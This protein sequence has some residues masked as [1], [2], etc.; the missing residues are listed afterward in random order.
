MQAHFNRIFFVFD[1][2]VPGAVF[3]KLVDYMRPHIDVKKIGIAIMNHVKETNESISRF[4]C[5]LIPV[6]ILCKANKIEDFIEF[7]KPAILAQFPTGDDAERITWSVE[8][9]RRNN[10]KVQKKDFVDVLTKE[11]DTVQHPVQY[12]DAKVEILIEIFRDMLIFAIL[13][14]YKSQFRKYNI[15]QLCSGKDEE[16]DEQATGGKVIK[17]SDLLKKKK[18][19]NAEEQVDVKE[20]VVDDS[21]DEDNAQIVYQPKIDCLEG[22]KGGEEKQKVSE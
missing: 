6:D 9:K 1:L 19:A 13:P 12:E 10:D 7:S 5:R 18:E 15:Q 11:I 3:I 8:F 20:K 2:G 14:G 21:S 17:L 4:A 16:E 22:K